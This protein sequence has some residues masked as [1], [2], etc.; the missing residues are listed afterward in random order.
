[1]ADQDSGR[2]KITE[3]HLKDLANQKLQSFLDDLRSD[4][5]RLEL[6]DYTGDGTLGA[7]VDWSYTQL[8][9]GNA[10]GNFPS[11]TRLQSTF[12]TFATALNERVKEIE[13]ATQQLIEDLR[14][15]DLVL[16]NAEDKNDI[17]AAEMNADLANISF[18]GTGTGTGTGT[19]NTNNGN[20]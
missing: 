4:P 8:L 5:H 13:T 6:A 12:K 16:T 14:H 15:V 20:T 3:D 7:R 11:S 18:G 9:P 19:G 1:M 17:T 10:K 2:L